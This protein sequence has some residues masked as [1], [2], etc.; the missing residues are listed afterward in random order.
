MQKTILIVDDTEVVR[1]MLADFLE[2]IY[3][4]I[5]TEDG[6]QA[7]EK[8]Q[9]SLTNQHS[10]DLVLTDLQMPGLDGYALTRNI[11]K[12]GNTPIVFI[13]GGMTIEQEKQAYATGANTCVHKPIKIEELEEKVRELLQ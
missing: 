9:Y 3:H 5:Q 1:N 7:W 4:V 2:P 8:Y 13:S 11:R 6:Q 12:K 10:V